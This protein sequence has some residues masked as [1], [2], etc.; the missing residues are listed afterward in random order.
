MRGKRERI[1]SRF[2]RGRLIPAHA[3][4]TKD[5]K[6][7]IRVHRAHPRACGENGAAGGMTARIRGSSPRMRG[8]LQSPRQAPGAYRLIP[9]H[10]GKTRR[11]GDAELDRWA[12]PRACGENITQSMP[13]L[14]NAGSSPR[15]RG[16]LSNLVSN[17]WNVRLIPAH[18]GKTR[19]NYIASKAS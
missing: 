5:G 2:I 11:R 19:A 8:K 7:L 1:S 3:G 9:A 6:S 14:S 18:A 4:K 10:A 12:H 15:M 17:L 13:Q 16:K